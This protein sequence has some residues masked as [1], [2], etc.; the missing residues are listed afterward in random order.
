[1]QNIFSHIKNAVIDGFFAL[2]PFLLIILVLEETFSLIDNITQPLV[3][4]LPGNEF[5]GIGLSSWIV[6]GI[7]LVTF[8][9]VGL[10]SRSRVGEQ[11]GNWVDD[12]IMRHIPGYQLLKSISQQFSGKG[13]ELLLSPALFTT[14]MGTWMFAFILDEYENDYYSLF[15]PSAPTPM[16][17]TVQYVPKSRVKKIDVPPG[18]VVDS[19]MQWGINAREVVN[20]LDYIERR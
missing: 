18:H 13:K 1:M 2:L 19:L 11:I 5:L 14:D 8:L 6:F 12:N 10:L 17:G 3:D 7:I 20:P 9:L 15:V 4:K 16:V